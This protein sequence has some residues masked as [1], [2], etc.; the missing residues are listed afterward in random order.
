MPRGP[1]RAAMNINKMID[2]YADRGCLYATAFLGTGQ[3]HCLDCPFGEGCVEDM[4][5]K[6]REGYIKGFT[7]GEAKGLI[8][9]LEIGLNIEKYT[10][11]II[12]TPKGG[13]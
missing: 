5:T 8:A 12:E 6:V 11:G 2:T 7:D 9:G 3:S 4:T 1:N 13:K 10:A